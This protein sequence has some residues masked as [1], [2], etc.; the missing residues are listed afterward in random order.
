M[1]LLE[2]V[3]RQDIFENCVASAQLNI[4]SLC[5]GRTVSLDLRLYIVLIGAANRTGSFGA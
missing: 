5:L 4:N 2:H 3:V 1:A